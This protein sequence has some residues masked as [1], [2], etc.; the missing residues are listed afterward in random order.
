MWG[1]AF[2]FFSKELSCTAL[3][4]A[5]V[6]CFVPNTGFPSRLYWFGSE[7][8]TRNMSNPDY[9]V[10]RGNTYQLIRLATLLHIPS[11][12]TDK[13]TLFLSSHRS[14]EEPHHAKYTIMLVSGHVCCACVSF[15]R[16][17]LASLQQQISDRRRETLDV[18][19][20]DVKEVRTR[21]N[22]EPRNYL[23]FLCSFALTMLIS[24]NSR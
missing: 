17:Y 21:L 1:V 6:T 3:A 24:K 18:S 8:D 10:E 2:F 12:V 16:E 4:L 23:F 5:H 13:C 15:H 11:S 9:K 14:A 19:L 22:V 20:A 7:I